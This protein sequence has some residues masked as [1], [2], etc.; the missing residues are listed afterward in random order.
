MRVEER[1]LA[2]AEEREIAETL[3]VSY[4][5]VETHVGSIL[6]KLGFTSRAQIAVWAVESAL[7]EHS[8]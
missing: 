6:S 1:S 5:A 7:V 3:V 2:I 4:R 8:E